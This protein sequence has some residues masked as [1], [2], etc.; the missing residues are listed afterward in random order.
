MNVVY[1]ALGSNLQSPQRQLRLA[2]TALR[3][4]PKT[5][6]LAIAPLY[7]NPAHGRRAQ[8]NFYNTVVKIVTT[9]TPYTLLEHCLQIEKNQG[10]ARRIK[11]QARTIDI[12]IIL[13]ASRRIKTHNLQIPHIHLHERDFVAI[14]L[15]ALLNHIPL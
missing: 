1:L 9:L 3:C 2:M 7:Y 4:L 5:H 8:P 10:R 14:P 6:V 15:A 11:W 13:Y 12:D